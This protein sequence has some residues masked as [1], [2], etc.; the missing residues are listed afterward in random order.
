MSAIDGAICR[1]GQLETME[2]V[3]CFV[4]FGVPVGYVDARRRDAT[5]FYCP[6]G[7]QMSYREGEADKLRRE[8]DRLKQEAARLEEEKRTAWLTATE[9]RER[10][11]AA[12]KREAQLKKRAAAG[13]CPC[14]SRNF[15]NLARHIKSKHPEFSPEQSA[16]VVALRKA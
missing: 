4:V 14:C 9:Q 15:T 2:C 3:N 5:T 6:N 12:E 11:E 7:H 8:R 10:A 1:A 13:S 16:R